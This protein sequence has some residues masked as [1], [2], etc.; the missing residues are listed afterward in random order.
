MKAKMKAKYEWSRSRL[1]DKL[2]VFVSELDE[3]LNDSRDGTIT[4]DDLEQR[5]QDK[6]DELTAL[7]EEMTELQ[8]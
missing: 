8:F 4:R 3:L 2:A 7:Y 6:M 1:A 5:I